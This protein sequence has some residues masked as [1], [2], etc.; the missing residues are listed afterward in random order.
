[1]F[2]FIDSIEKIVPIYLLIFVRLTSMMV[3][4]P[5]FSHALINPRFRSLIAFSFTLIIGSMILPNS[6]LNLSSIWQ[7]AILIISEALLGFILGFGT[8]IVFEAFSVA[9]TMIGLQMGIAYANIIDPTTRQQVPIISQFLML[10]AI[11][12]LFAI[13][14][15]L[16]I[17]ETMVRHFEIIPLGLSQLSDQTGQAI[18]KG[19]SMM[20]LKGL[21]FAAPAMIMLLLIDTGIG[22]MA[23]VMPQMNIFFVA[24]PVKIGVGIIMLIFSVNIFQSMFDIIFNDLVMITNELISSF[25]I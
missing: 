22:F 8:K 11:L 12:F 17:I 10:L 7:F 6:D 21:Q 13:D 23:R 18:I 20:F 3:V 2:E 4:M 14:G 1:M 24:L 9:G 16:F 15:H 5:I 19:G 25:R